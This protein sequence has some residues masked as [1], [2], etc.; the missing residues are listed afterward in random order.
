[1]T[2]QTPT[3][4][5]VRDANRSWGIEHVRWMVH[6]G[7]WQR[8]VR[9]VLVRHS[10]T[11]T[12]D[13]RIL[14]ELLAQ[15]SAAAVAGLTAAALDGLQGFTTSTIFLTVPHTVRVRPRS[16]VVVKRTRT[17]SPDDIHPARTPRRTRLPRSIVDAASWATTELRCQAILASGVQQGLVTPGQ[18]A[19]VVE[20]L[21]ALRHRALVC[22]TIRDV[23]GGSLSEYEVLFIRLCREYHLPTPTRQRR[24]RDASGRWRY[25]DIEFDEYR[26]V[27]EIDG[28]QHME[29][30]AW[31]DDMARNNEIVVDEG[32]TLVRFAGFALRHQRAEVAR[33]LLTFFAGRDPVG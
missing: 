12:L 7:R 23:G 14:V 33:V 29:V 24:R 26:L 13:E 20:K 28:Q 11:L 1:M 2:P 30:L 27:V 16:G 25:L 3:V 31:W 18:L 10:G 5:R 15:P 32:K 19:A 17:L 22:E 9:G 21:P 8:P 6:S 4:V